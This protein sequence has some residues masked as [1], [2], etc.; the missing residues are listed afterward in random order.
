MTDA[1]NLTI[2]AFQT[3]KYYAANGQ[4]VAATRLDNGRVLFVDIDRNITG[5]TD[6]IPGSGLTT[7]KVMNCYDSGHYNHATCHALI[8]S[9]DGFTSA[10]WTTLLY[11]YETLIH[12]LRRA[13]AAVPAPHG[14]THRAIA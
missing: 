8:D 13:A 10:E 12:A 11:R 5:V 2:I 14:L 9:S 6:K 3:G 1:T 4:R 7:Y